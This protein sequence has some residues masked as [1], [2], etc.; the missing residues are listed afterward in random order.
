MSGEYQQVLSNWNK[1][2]MKHALFQ[3][4]NPQVCKGKPPKPPLFEL[5]PSLKVEIKECIISCLDI[6]TVE[7]LR[8]E[9]VTVMIPSLVQKV[10]TNNETETLGYKLLMTYT[11]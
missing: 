2:F 9:L 1:E 11:D 8:N 4:P 7:M 6:F 10:M 5:F 3:H